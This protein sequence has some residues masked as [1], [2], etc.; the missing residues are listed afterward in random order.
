MET[1]IEKYEKPEMEVII[2]DEEDKQILMGGDFLSSEN[3]KK[4]LFPS[5]EQHF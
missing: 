5:T 4:T 1:K 3:F 2:F